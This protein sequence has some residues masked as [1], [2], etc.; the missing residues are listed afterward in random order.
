MTDYQKGDVVWHRTRKCLGVVQKPPTPPFR[1]VQVQLTIHATPQYCHQSQITKDI[2]P[3]TTTPIPHVSEPSGGEGS[4]QAFN[5]GDQVWVEE[6]PGTVHRQ[7]RDNIDKVCVI[8]AGE[9]KSRY[10]LK[11]LVT[12]AQLADGTTIVGAPVSAKL[13]PTVK[14]VEISAAVLKEVPATQ[15]SI[16]GGPAAAKDTADAPPQPRAA[17]SS[18]APIQSLPP[19]KVDTP[20]ENLQRVRNQAFLDL[21]ELDR[22]LLLMQVRTLLQE[23]VSSFVVQPKPAEVRP[24]KLLPGA[25]KLQRDT[26]IALDAAK[27]L[28]K[29]GVL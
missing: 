4:Y 11:S 1:C 18:G 13:K 25:T 28:S 29:L 26:A 5:K 17:M 15:G 10:Y 22:H 21:Q 14:Q 23:A 3:G 7:T 20:L 9:R 6:N 16:T 19:T 2:P 27:R 8:M 12:R 24:E